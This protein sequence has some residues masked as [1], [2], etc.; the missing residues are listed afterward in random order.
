MK[1]WSLRLVPDRGQQAGEAAA[2]LYPP[3]GRAEA[4]QDS[5]RPGDDDY[6][7]ITRNGETL[8]A[9]GAGDTPKTTIRPPWPSSPTR[10]RSPLAPSSHRPR[11]RSVPHRAP[12]SVTAWAA[13]SLR[14]GLKPWADPVQDSNRTRPSA[15]SS[16]CSSRP[17]VPAPITTTGSPHTGL[18]RRMPSTTHA[19]GSAFAPAQVH[20]INSHGQT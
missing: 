2:V 19:S 12:A 8:I 18:R 5:H 7:V 3:S 17:V 15:C 1:C 14:G 9:A 20:L 6:V 4:G 11:P 10:S 13:P 16:N